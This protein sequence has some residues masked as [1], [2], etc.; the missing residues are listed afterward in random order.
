MPITE[1][2]ILDRA[3]ALLPVLRERAPETE[4]LR[5]LHPDSDREFKA[6]GFYRIMQP[7]HYGGLELDFGS[8]TAL[9]TELGRACGSSS[10]VAT[11]IACHG[12][13]FGMFPKRAQ[14]EVWGRSADETLATAFYCERST[15]KRVAGG[16]E[17]SGKW[18]FSSGIHNCGWVLPLVAVPNAE[19]PPTP[20]FVLLE[21]GEYQVE[22]VWNSVGLAG[23]GSNDFTVEGVFIPPHRMLDITKLTGGPSPGSEVNDFYLYRQPMMATFAF[24]LVG[25]IIGV[26]RGAADIVIGDLTQN[27]T[28]KAGAAMVGMPTIQARVAESLAEIDAA[29]AMVFRNRDEIVRHGQAGTYPDLAAR[30][31]YRGNNGLAAKLSVSAIDRLLPILGAR[32]LDQS[33]PLQRAWR[34]ARAIAQHAALT[35]DVNANIYGAIALGLP[36]PAPI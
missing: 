30:G 35:W 21:Q 25:N 3:R 17:I 26:A 11:I 10:W 5:R 1:D 36:S 6:A 22:E 28:T 15:V 32:G 13:L 2:D 34:D 4:R 7:R 23:T 24:N 9:G 8:Q 14:D 19:G 31:R 16:I 20:H 18:R 29:Y 33:H 12:W 27:R